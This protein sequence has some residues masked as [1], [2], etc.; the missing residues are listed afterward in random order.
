[1]V[2]HSELVSESDP[3]SIPLYPFKEKT[4][5]MKFISHPFFYFTPRALARTFSFSGLRRA[6][7]HMNA[8]KRSYASFCIL[9][10]ASF[11]LASCTLK[12]QWPVVRVADDA[13]PVP[14]TSVPGT[15][16]VVA[17]TSAPG[18]LT[19]GCQP[20]RELGP[21]APNDGLGENF[22]VTANE[23]VSA[24][25][26]VQLWWPAGSGQDWGKE[27]ISVL[28]PSGLSIEVQDG[29][30]RGWEYALACTAEDISQQITADNARRTTDTAFYGSVDIDSLITTG[31]VTVRFD[32]RTNA[33]VLTPVAGQPT[34]T[35]SV[36]RATRA[37]VVAICNATRNGDSDGLATIVAG[38]NETLSVEAWGGALGD[39][40]VVVPAG[41]TIARTWQG[42]AIW[43]YPCSDTAAVIRD[44]SNRG[45]PIYLAKNGVLTTP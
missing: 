26:H 18:P 21:W 6:Q 9:F 24:G 1:M 15:P 12:F 42:G 7:K 17:S 31:L 36:A 40:F 43:Q 23:T 14:A 38:S 27:E 4:L 8:Q 45:K 25:V 11:L 5:L 41:Q 33:T 16:P 22:E 35:A 2:R 28:V 34:T 20:A 19:E 32:R 30:G 37:P 29:A 10:V 44:V 39:S 3:L 13:N